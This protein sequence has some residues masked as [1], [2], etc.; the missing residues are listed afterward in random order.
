MDKSKPPAL[1]VELPA[2]L[3]PVYTNFALIS[4]SPSE[5]IFDLS[6]MLPNNP[7]VRVKARVIMTPLNAKLLLRALQ[8]NLTKYEAAFG[9]I[10]L[11][12]DAGTLAREFFGGLRPP[13]AE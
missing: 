5:M 7:K 4:H 9:V 6:Q 2:D 10:A 12:G 8:E 13:G 3:E 11:P 1:S